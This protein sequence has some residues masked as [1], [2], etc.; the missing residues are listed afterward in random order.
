MTRNRSDRLKRDIDRSMKAT[1][2][3]I[4][5]N[6]LFKRLVAAEAKRRQR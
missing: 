6:P 5:G 1:M 3:A 4:L 2:K